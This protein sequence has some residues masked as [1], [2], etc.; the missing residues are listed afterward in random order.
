MVGKVNES[1][2][3]IERRAKLHMPMTEQEQQNTLASENHI[4][5]QRVPPVFPEVQGV[6]GHISPDLT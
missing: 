6:Y 1:H 2:R 3:K 5:G 4:R